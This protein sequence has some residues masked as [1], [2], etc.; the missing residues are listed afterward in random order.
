[1]ADVDAL[2]QALTLEEK[3]ALTA[4]GGM[5]ST[6]P[7]ERL[8]IPV[9]NVTDGPNGARGPSYPG[10]GGPPSTCIP[11]GSALGAT[12]DTELVGALGALVGREALD[13]GCRGLLA[14][15]VNLHR[16]PL[17][18]TELRVLLGGSAALRSSGRGLRA[19]G[20]V[21][22]CLRH[23]QALR[24]QRGGVRARVHQLRDRRA[25]PARAVPAP[26]R[27]RRPRGRG[28]GDHDGVQP[29]Q[30]E[31]AARAAPLPRRHP[32][33]GVGL[34]GSGHDGLVRRR[35][36]RDRP[37]RRP[38]PGDARTRAGAG[39]GPGRPGRAGNGA[40]GR[41]RCRRPAAAGRLRPRR[42]PGCADAPARAPGAPGRGR[43]APPAGR[44]RGDGA[45]AQRRSPPTGSGVAAEGG[46]DR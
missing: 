16:S 11:C 5:M 6:A 33:R 38:R 7:V 12:W 45:A 4:G 36:R 22:R 20:A 42:C 23:R 14:P 30:R 10:I 28:D 13:R 19:G 3:A 27:A 46:G 18:G 37:P 26:L 35:R 17:A 43:R 34:R 41:P 2:V 44:R 15:T 29:G 21:E 8:G 40:R 9:V 24:R 31:V 39:L 1:M 32:A 25:L